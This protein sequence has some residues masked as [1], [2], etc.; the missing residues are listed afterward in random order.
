MKFLDANPFVY[1]FYKPR[2]ALTVEEARMKEE[3]KAIVNKVNRGEEQVL[4]S[5]VHI[6]EVSNILKRKMTIAELAELLS[7]LLTSENVQVEGVTAEDYLGATESAPDLGVDPNDSLAVRL[8]RSHG[9][10]DIFTFD[11]GFD[12]IEGVKRVP[13]DGSGATPTTPSSRV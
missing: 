11:R 1:A 7:G 13:G 5:V 10:Q 4:T 2:R 3:A 12:K 6:S 8:M 9:V